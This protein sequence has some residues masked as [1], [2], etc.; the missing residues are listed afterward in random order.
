MA[1][2]VLNNIHVLIRDSTIVT[3]SNQLHIPD[4]FY[5]SVYY[6][7]TAFTVSKIIM[8]VHSYNPLGKTLLL[9]DCKLLLL[10]DCKLQFYMSQLCKD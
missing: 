4:I 1:H 7:S 8:T 3:R 9:Q 5:V 6:L 10:Q 2:S